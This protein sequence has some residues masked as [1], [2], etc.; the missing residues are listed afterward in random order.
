MLSSREPVF[1][2]MPL[3]A[4]PWGSI[5]IRRV[6]FSA[7]LRAAARFMEVVVLPTPPFWLAT[8]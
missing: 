1:W 4:F 5:S 7:T 2:P 6:F 8:G 3:V